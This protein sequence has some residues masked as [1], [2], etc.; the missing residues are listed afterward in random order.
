MC[1]YKKRA[2]ILLVIPITICLTSIIFY[3]LLFPAPI[4][5]IRQIESDLPHRSAVIINF[6]PPIGPGPGVWEQLFSNK[7][8]IYNYEI[9]EVN[10]VDPQGNRLK[11]LTSDRAT[12]ILCLSVQITYNPMVRTL[13]PPGRTNPEIL[14]YLAQKEDGVWSVSFLDNRAGTCE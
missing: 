1:V 2:L 12:K 6:G 4:P 14:H 11:F 5:V 8:E 13:I 7:E 9:V 10:Q 3:L